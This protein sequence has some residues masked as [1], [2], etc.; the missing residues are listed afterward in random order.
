MLS[1]VLNSTTETIKIVKNQRCQDG[2]GDIQP[3]IEV[4][5][6]TNPVALIQLLNHER[7]EI[8]A[9]V[10]AAAAGFDADAVTTCFETYAGRQNDTLNPLTGQVW[11]DGE[12][13]DVAANHDGI[14]KGWVREALGITAVNR[15]GDYMF[16]HLPYHYAP[17]LLWGQA[18]IASTF[19]QGEA[20]IVGYMPKRL[21]AAMALPSMGVTS[22]RAARMNRTDRDLATAA[23]IGTMVEARVGL[24]AEADQADRITA[25]RKFSTPM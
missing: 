12:M 22:G 3:M 17:H 21:I 10:R 8:L 18:G 20:I 1:D 2:P 11:G 9:V 4:Y 24:Y 19:E 14:A 16:A 25:L 7:D 6:G 23:F 15:A 5:R 13:Q